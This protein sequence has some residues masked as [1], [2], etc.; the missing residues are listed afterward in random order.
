MKRL[1][2][3]FCL[4]ATLN[5][6]EILSSFDYLWMDQVAYAEEVTTKK[7]E[8]P[9][10][11]HLIRAACRLPRRHYTVEEKWM[12]FWSKQK[13]GLCDFPADRC[14]WLLAQKP[15]MKKEWTVT[16]TGETEITK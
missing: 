1:A 15:K 3:L 11:S 4:A 14:R 10:M 13:C 12:V 9:N 2:I 8:S 7:Y 16:Q 6:V 5:A